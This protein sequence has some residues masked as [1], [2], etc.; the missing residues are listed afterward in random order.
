MGGLALAK[1]EHTSW[2]KWAMKVLITIFIVNIIILTVAMLI[3]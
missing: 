1:V 2:I 3:L